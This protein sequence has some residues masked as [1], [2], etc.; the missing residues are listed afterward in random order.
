MLTKSSTK[1]Q[2]NYF[3]RHSF[4]SLADSVDGFAV[5]VLNR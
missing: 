4:S 1:L 2:K 5:V 3:T